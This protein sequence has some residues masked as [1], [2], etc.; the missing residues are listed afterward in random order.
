MKRGEGRR[1]EE[2][3]GNDEH[4]QRGDVVAFGCVSHFMFLY[5]EIK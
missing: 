5:N 3:E 4:P 1:E 2:E